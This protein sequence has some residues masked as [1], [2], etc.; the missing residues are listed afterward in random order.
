MLV[1]VGPLS[2]NEKN[3][4]GIFV[5]NTNSVEEAEKLIRND[6]VISEGILDAEIYNWYSSAALPEYHE[7]AKKI[8]KSRP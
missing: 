8:W 5:F 6:A 2:K 3:Y 4:R 7:I 1:A